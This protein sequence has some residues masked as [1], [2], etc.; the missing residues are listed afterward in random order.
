M[1]A[2]FGP[3]RTCPAAS[4]RREEGLSA[5]WEPETD[6]TSARLGSKPRAVPAR[7]SKLAE[8]TGTCRACMH[9]AAPMDLDIFDP[10]QAQQQLVWPSMCSAEDRR[11]RC[12]P[13]PGAVGCGL[14]NLF[15]VYSAPKGSLCLFLRAVW[16]AVARALFYIINQVEPPLVSTAE[17]KAP[18]VLRS[19]RRPPTSRLK[20]LPPRPHVPQLQAACASPLL[21]CYNKPFRRAPA[22]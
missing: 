9:E 11:S 14:S 17:N 15:S 18:D 2:Q 19:M 7:M 21:T 6:P 10:T 20:P 4:Q 5:G 3:L 16:L 8:T 1:L 22:R 13:A 12:Y